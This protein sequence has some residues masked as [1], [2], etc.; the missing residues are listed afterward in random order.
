MPNAVSH[1]GL[2]RSSPAAERGRNSVRPRVF[3]SKPGKMFL[4]DFVGYEL[5]KQLFEGP[6]ALIRHRPLGLTPDFRHVPLVEYPAA[7]NNCHV[8]A[9]FFN[10]I[11]DVRRDHD[12]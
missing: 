5:H 10:G 12:R 3:T 8:A 9:E 6:Q 4:A 1:R 11:E 2:L 7:M